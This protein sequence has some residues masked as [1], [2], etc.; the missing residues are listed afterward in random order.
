MRTAQNIAFDAPAIAD[1]CRAQWVDSILPELIN[2]I[3]IPC[4]SPL[5]DANWRTHG[6]LDEATAQ[7]AHWAERQKVQG[8]RLETLRLPERT[9]LLFIDIPAFPGNSAATAEDPAS[10]P[11]VLFYGHLDKQPEMTGWREDLGPWTPKVE[12]NRLYG[13]GGADDGYALFASLCAIA[14]LQSLNIPHAPC[15]ILIEASEE[16]GS[17]DLP[18]YLK[19]LEQRIGTPDLAV[20]LDSGCGNYHQLWCS[21]SLRGMIN[22]VLEVKLLA[23]GV[24]S[25]DAGGV[26]PDTF[27]LIQRLL[28]R[29]ENMETGDVLLSACHTPIPAQRRQQ[30]AHAAAVL[31]EET[32]RRF[33]LLGAGRPI[34]ENL[35]DLILN[36]TWKPALAVTGADGL[37]AVSNAGNVLRPATALRLALRLPP[38]CCA[39]TAANQ[40]RETLLA[41]PPHNAQVTVE[42]DCAATGWHAPAMAPWLDA[43]MQQASQEFYGKS[44]IYMGD[45]VTIPFMDMLGKSF[46]D[47]Q[48]LVTGVL[49]PHA[50]AHGPNE[51]LHLAFAEKLTACLARVLSAHCHHH[52]LH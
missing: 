8:L 6:Y 34:T 40:L 47:S 16:S 26:L 42:I 46:P 52:G 12:G 5:F 25:G 28:A 49:G 18:A 9:P 51:F 45:G 14:A 23:E 36:R 29:I 22:C 33:P 4:K 10:H 15:Q 17:P 11:H 50:N 1:F 21:T 7:F 41:N 31:G 3:R 19:A 2:Y 27:R 20:C 30:A 44:A 48:F 13:R 35:E 43:A 32:W 39:E 24:H 37:P 38:D